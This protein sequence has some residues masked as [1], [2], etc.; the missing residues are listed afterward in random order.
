MELAQPA[1]AAWGL[2]GSNTQQLVVLFLETRL[3]LLCVLP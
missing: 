2:L 1:L 3:C